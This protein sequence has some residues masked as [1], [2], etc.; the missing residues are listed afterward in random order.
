MWNSRFLTELPS[1]HN[2]AHD[3]IIPPGAS[4]ST[5]QPNP[6]RRIQ[7]QAATI[8]RIYG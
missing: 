1:S 2:G 5:M 8:P 4:A 3:S 7:K 6:I